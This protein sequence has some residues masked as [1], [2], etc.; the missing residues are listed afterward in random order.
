MPRFAMKRLALMICFLFNLT[1]CQSVGRPGV[2]DRLAL[3]SFSQ[4]YVEVRI[5]LEIDS[6]GTAWL[7]ATFTPLDA[8][9]HLY[10]LDLPRDGVNGVGR[11]T[12]LEL[13]AGSQMQ[14]LG[15]LTASA[16]ATAEEPSLPD[17]HV[18]PPGPVTLRL[19]VALPPGADWVE[20]QVSVT[21]MSCKGSA[22]RPPLMNYLVGVRVPGADLIAP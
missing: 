8:G 13:P 2:G 18:Y 4:N 22:C 14:A 16:V 9:A 11:P 17:L 1:A 7:A 5:V 6:D 12:L 21:Y 15:P 19:P 10:A 20:T 3:A